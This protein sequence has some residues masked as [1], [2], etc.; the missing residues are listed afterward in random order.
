M[1]ELKNASLTIDGRKLFDGLSLMAHDGQLTLITG[2]SGSG[3]TALLRVMLGLLPLDSGLV[4]VDGEL[5]TP[6]SANAFRRLMVYLPQY[7]SLSP[8]RVLS[9]SIAEEASQPAPSQ[10]LSGST[11]EKALQPLTEGFQPVWHLSPLADKPFVPNPLPP[12]SASLPSLSPEKR[13]LLLDNPD[14]ALLPRLKTLAADK[15][16][17]IVA[18]QREEY[19]NLSDKQI[20]LG[21][22]NLS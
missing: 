11:A 4:S 1:L 17:V 18:S 7:P 3:K 13:I 22:G 15:M 20:I 6:L 19:F 5:L 12:T 8:Y 10:V 2:P 9:G 21:N 14:P 16:T